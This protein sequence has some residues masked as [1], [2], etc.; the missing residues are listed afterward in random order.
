MEYKPNTSK[1]GYLQG[2]GGR[3]KR[4]K[5][6]RRLDFSNVLYFVELTLEPC[7]CFKY[8]KVKILQDGLKKEIPKD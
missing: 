4:R 5:I 1:T 6:Y 2:E 8:Y 3:V 7:L